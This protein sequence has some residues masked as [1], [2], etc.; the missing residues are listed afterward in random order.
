MSDQFQHKGYE[1]EVD[2]DHP[3]GPLV[4]IGDRTVPVH[5]IGKRFVVSELPYTEAENLS[6]LAKELVEQSR[7]I[8]TNE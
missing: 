6:D 4:K 2:E 3:E 8:V 1:I 5:R 7:D